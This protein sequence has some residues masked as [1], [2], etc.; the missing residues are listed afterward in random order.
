M[1]LQNNN[2]YKQS[3]MS[4]IVFVLLV[5]L[6][7]TAS[8]VGVMHSV[9]NTQQINSASN[10][11]THAQN[12]TW[13]GVAAFQKYLNTL[14][15]AELAELPAELAI[16]MEPQYGDL[17]ARNI[18]VN[19]EPDG[20]LRIVTDIVNVHA[21]AKSSYAV[22]TVYGIDTGAGGADAEPLPP[23]LGFADS[24]TIDGGIEFTD[25]GLPAKI[26]VD[27]DVLIDGV[28]INPLETKT[29][30][31]FTAQ[32]G[33]SATNVWAN[34]EVLLNASGRFENVNT[35]NSINVTRAGGDGHGM[36]NAGDEVTTSVG[37]IDHLRAVG[38]INMSQWSA[39]ET[40]IS[41][42]NV[43]CVA[44]HWSEYTSIKANGTTINCASDSSVINGASET[45]A[46]MD[47]VPAVAPVEFVV[48]VWELKEDANY[49][50]EWDSG[51]NKIKVTVNNVNNITDGSE[52]YLGSYDAQGKTS[53]Y[54]DY[55]C[56]I[57]NIHG[58]C[59][60]PNTPTLPLCFGRSL[61]NG[62]ISYNSATGTWQ[63]DPSQTVPGVLFFDGDLNLTS[64]EA[65]ST[66]LASGDISTSSGVVVSSVNFGGYN[67]VCLADGAHVTSRS[68][69]RYVD[70]Y[71]EY[72]P[73][74]LCDK[75]AAEYIP[76]A[77]GNVA[78][79][80]G[81]FHPDDG[82]DVF[83][84]GNIDLDSS[85]LISGAVLAGN[86]ISTQ[87]Q[88]I[89]KGMVVAAGGAEG[90]EGS[91]S[92]S[93]HTEIDLNSGVDY[94]PFNLPVISAAHGSSSSNTEVGSRVMWVRTL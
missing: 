89:I 56:E 76:T 43:N 4:S 21:A 61:S 6:A 47:P 88:V 26:I 50:I 35:L 92:L 8:T 24:L 94:D 69:T 86:V 23:I 66:F 32:G 19:N 17:V 80:A 18:S 20:S 65:V 52:Y 51:V 62:C 2:I 72:Y 44:P 11:I 53:P 15:A 79:A 81:G 82:G 84:G 33:S 63:L 38:D 14:D 5:G 67:K 54:I 77:L 73:T 87:G 36:L 7:I 16:T 12:G 70:T 78:L 34:G 30:G 74:N 48:D 85:S 3:G 41:M 64:E 42:A 49:F 46:V 9:I 71:S 58:K 75:S 29:Q 59:T 1:N 22:R 27:G 60:Q 91:N 13:S 45:V 25:A 83:S 28:N 40:A 93:G 10:A 39:I 31:N 90:M 57:V 37:P 55:L 68:Q